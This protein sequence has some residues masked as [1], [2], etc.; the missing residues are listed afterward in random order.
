VRLHVVNRT[1]PTPARM[2]ARAPFRLTGDPTRGHGLRIV[3]S[4]AAEHG[5]RFAACRHRD[6]ASAVLELPLA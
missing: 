5:G 2:T 1:A 4:I 3:R 6:G